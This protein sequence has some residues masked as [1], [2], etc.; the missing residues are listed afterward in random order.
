MCK[1][2]AAGTALKSMLRRE[3]VLASRLWLEQDDDGCRLFFHRNR[4][5]TSGLVEVSKCSDRSARGSTRSCFV[6]PSPAVVTQ[7]HQ[8]S[9]RRSQRAA[10]LAGSNE[11]LFNC[12]IGQQ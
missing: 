7:P 3:H 10:V 9:D 8:L 11:R 1:Q 4:S 2:P 6:R 5:T 12:D